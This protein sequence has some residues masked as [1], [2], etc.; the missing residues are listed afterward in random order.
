MVNN[1]ILKNPKL[2]IRLGAESRSKVKCKIDKFEKYKRFEELHVL[3]GGRM[4]P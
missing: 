4:H 2:F 3:L 1:Q